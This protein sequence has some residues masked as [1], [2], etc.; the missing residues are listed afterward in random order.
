LF[1]VR[2]EQGKALAFAN[3]LPSFK[4]GEATI[5][6]MR[7]KRNAPK[8]IMDYLF[9]ELMRQLHEEGAERFNLGLSPLARQ[10]FTDNFSEKLLDY[11][12]LISQRFVSTKGLHQYKAKFDPVWEPRY[13]YF[14]G[15]TPSLPQIGFALSKLSLYKDKVYKS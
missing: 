9:I 10:E 6:L 14:L 8:N 13:V 7:H 2:D 12:Y 1:V 3:E 15:S 4:K 5:D 11:I